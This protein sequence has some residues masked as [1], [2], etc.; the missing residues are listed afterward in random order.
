MVV[1]YVLWSVVMLWHLTVARTPAGCSSYRA[2][3]VAGVQP[4]VK[5]ARR[6]YRVTLNIWPSAALN[7]LAP[8]Y[9]VGYLLHL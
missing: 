1:F 6:R 8:R 9:C 3:F 7:N 5:Q 2:A 4:C